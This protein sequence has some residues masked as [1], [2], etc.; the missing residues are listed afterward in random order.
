[1]MIV[2]DQSE[3]N[4]TW[5]NTW[6][7]AILLWFVNILLLSFGLCRLLLY[8]DPILPA[9][10][11][12]FVEVNR[13][14]CQAEY[15]VSKNDY[16]EAYH[17]LSQCVRYFSRRLPYTRRGIFIATFWEMLR[18]L[19][20]RVYVSRLLTY[21]VKKFANKS[22]RQR[23][24]ITAREM[25]LLYQQILCLKLSQVN[26]ANRNN[27]SLIYIA[28]SALNYAEASG[29]NMPHS[30]L[31]EI[32]VNAALCFKEFSSS[33]SSVTSRRILRLPASK[34]LHLLFEYYLR[35]ARVALSLCAEP[36]AP[37][38]LKW[39]MSEDGARFMVEHGWSYGPHTIIRN[40][41]EFTVQNNKSEPLSYAARAYRE[42]L[43]TQGLRMLAGTAGNDAHASALLDVSRKIMTSARVDLCIRTKEDKI[44]ITS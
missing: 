11:Q 22:R 39:L 25:A 36:P 19:L 6:N 2:S 14:R 9:G 43:I 5:W 21:L 4:E 13:K 34:L 1:M 15:N 16:E 8:G 26:Y 20:H 27:R 3:Y 28:L 29:E 35:K 40:E 33:W 7:T 18:Q 44:G 17:E 32:Y 30:I 23:A 37:Q 12:I 31:A 42:H 41:S 24:E 10:S 38:K